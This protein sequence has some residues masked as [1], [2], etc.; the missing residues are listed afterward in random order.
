MDI[1]RL[2][3]QIWTTRVSRIN[4]E[5]RLINKEKF[6]QAINI[7]YSC[8]TIIFSIL[9]INNDDNQ[10]SLITT[11]MSICL[12]VTI[13]YLNSQRYME[14]AR[15][16][17]TNYTSLQKLEMLLDNE[18][19]LPQRIEEIQMEY[20]N[21]MDSACNHIQYDYYSSVAA[22]AR[23]RVNREWLVSITARRLRS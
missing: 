11:F 2:K 1:K 23:P 18:D 6:I 13:L 4:A 17:R 5:R 8:V 22:P 15:D 16:F 21:L 12:L 3:D 10:L 20:C 7:Y 9:S 14:F 19:I